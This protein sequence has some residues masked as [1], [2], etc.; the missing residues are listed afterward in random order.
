MKYRY[1]CDLDFPLGFYAQGDFLGIKKRKLDASL[2]Y[3]ECPANWAGVFTTNKFRSYS[4]EDAIS[5]KK[6][7]IRAVGVFSGNANTCTGQEGRD[8][9]E[10]L[11]NIVGD[12]FLVPA[13][14]VLL[15]FTGVIGIPFPVKK[16]A[17][18]F[19]KKKSF[20]FLKKIIKGEKNEI[21]KF[22]PFY[23][24]ILTTDTRSKKIAV[25]IPLKEGKIRIA[26][27]AKGSGMIA[28]NMATMLAYISTDLKMSN[29]ECRQ[30]LKQFTHDSFNSI[31]VDGDSSTNDSVFLI[32]NGASQI[33]F[34]KL[35]LEE[36]K[37]VD[38]SLEFIC[39]YLAK[40]IVRDGEGA[41][42]F[43]TIK[44]S[45]A[46]D[47]NSA[48]VISKSIANSLLVKTAIFGHDPNYG[49][50]L[51][52]VGNAGVPIQ[53]NKV[54]LKFG[55]SLLYSNEKLRKDKL[56]HISNYMKKNKEILIDVKVGSG[57]GHHTF[58]TCD[59][60]YEYVKI[61]AEYTT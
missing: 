17:Q 40:E 41:S 52:A 14:E 3:S 33:E 46:K 44:I 19:Q 61:N 29:L 47:K 1:D 49:R 50:I 20:Q 32:A 54:V 7:K 2:L 10:T 36:Q 16:T 4:L 59:I 28:P 35:S 22:H 12:N 13:S 55:N 18:N 30:K 26:A 8:S 43:I 58:H 57:L 25:E 45:G 6:N 27:C 53:L 23:D 34:K 9:V 31:S 38:K 42:K 60:S 21:D 56:K 24:S 15:S 37:K 51:M 39:Q 11:S 48:F 5:K